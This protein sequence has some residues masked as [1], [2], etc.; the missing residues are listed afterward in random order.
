MVNKMN[1]FFSFYFNIKK[2]KEST[3]NFFIDLS[4]CHRKEICKK[5]K[6]NYWNLKDKNKIKIHHILWNQTQIK[7]W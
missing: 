5:K 1:K 3:P 2:I 4:K 7:D 6:K